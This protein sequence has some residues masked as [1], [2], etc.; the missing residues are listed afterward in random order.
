MAAARATQIR[1]TFANLIP[2]FPTRSGRLKDEVRLEAGLFC[3]PHHGT[4]KDGLEFTAVIGEVTMRLAKDGNNLRHLE[5]EHSVL[6]GKRGSMTLRFVL[7]AFGRVRPDLDALVGQRSP[8]ACAAYG[9]AH[10]EAT[11]ADPIH[12]LR[13]LAIVV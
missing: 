3:A 8:V 9:A 2:L 7:L 11:L 12:S 10:P 6:V 13:A 1:V 4:Q 5:T